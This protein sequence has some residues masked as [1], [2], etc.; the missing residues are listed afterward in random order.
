MATTGTSA[1]ENNGVVPDVIDEQQIIDSL[2]GAIAARTA[3]RDELV[4]EA[5]R[6]GL[7]IRR[8]ERALAPLLNEDKPRKD[9]PAS[10]GRS[11]SRLRATRFASAAKIQMRRPSIPRL[12]R[13]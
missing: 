12:A 5:T 9:R 13:R 1:I 2:R 6:I 4:A 11:K 10:C 3:Y 8:Y 7:E